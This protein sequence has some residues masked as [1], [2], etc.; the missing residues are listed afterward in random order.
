MLIYVDERDQSDMDLM[1][2]IDFYIARKADEGQEERLRK[3][4][5]SIKIQRR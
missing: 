2:A 4:Y 5:D 1:E 3:I